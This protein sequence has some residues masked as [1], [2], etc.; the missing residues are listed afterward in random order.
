MEVNFCL[1]T[2][3]VKLLVTS[4]VNPP[5]LKCIYM[6]EKYANTRG[7]NPLL[8]NIAN[9]FGRPPILSMEFRNFIFCYGAA[10]FHIFFT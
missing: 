1:N 5:Y 2:T 4:R 6:V 10:V 9:M 3:S 8:I 7:V